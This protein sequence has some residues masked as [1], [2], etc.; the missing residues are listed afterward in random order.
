M[1][2][3]AMAGVITFVLVM[4][5]LRVG[6]TLRCWWKSQSNAKQ[7]K[8]SPDGLAVDESGSEHPPK[9]E[10]DVA[11]RTSEV[12]IG[13]NTSELPCAEFSARQDE[14]AQWFHVSPSNSPVHGVYVTVANRDFLQ[15]MIMRRLPPIFRLHGRTPLGSILTIF[16]KFFP[17]FIQQPLGSEWHL[18]ASWK[19]V[20]STS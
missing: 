6:L 11:P 2:S 8:F 13:M 17:G 10:L 15:R 9:S 14:C 3:G 19:S 4:L 18:V 12:W 5:M 1:I 20:C 16:D 7:L